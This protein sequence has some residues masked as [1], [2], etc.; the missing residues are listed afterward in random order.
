M[1]TSNNLENKTPSHT[2]WDMFMNIRHPHCKLKIS[3]NEFLGITS[4]KL[5]IFDE[6]FTLCVFWYHKMVG[7]EKTSYFPS[8]SQKMI[9]N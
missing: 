6:T 1:R 3:K 8:L 4:E 2:Y 5:H 7:I 9:K